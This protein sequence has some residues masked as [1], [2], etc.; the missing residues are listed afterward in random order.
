MSLKEEY[1][2]IKAEYE[3]IKYMDK[4]AYKVALSEKEYINSDGVRVL[5]KDMAWTLSDSD[6]E[7][8][9]K[10][11]DKIRRK[12]GMN[13]PY[14]NYPHIEPWNLSAD[15]IYHKKL[16]E[17]ENKIIKK[18]AEI[19]GE[20]EEDANKI[21]VTDPELKKKFIETALKLEDI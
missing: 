10:R 8:L 6:F 3:Y 11:V 18:A 5:S 4:A 12:M 9:L 2:L 21:M 15:V 16:I 7:K 13:L 14:D 1:E 17:I 19:I 20:T